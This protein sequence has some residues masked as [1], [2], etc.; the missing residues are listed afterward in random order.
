MNIKTIYT[1]EGKIL[2]E[3]VVTLTVE[4]Y[5]TMQIIVDTLRKIQKDFDLN[6]EPEKI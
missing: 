6:G 5:K 4:D 3:I 1:T 2:T